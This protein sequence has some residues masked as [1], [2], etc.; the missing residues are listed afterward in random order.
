[1]TAPMSISARIQKIEDGMAAIEE[2]F[3]DSELPLPAWSHIAEARSQLLL[4]R[5]SLEQNKKVWDGI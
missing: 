5:N 3:G 1:M 2:L 4:A